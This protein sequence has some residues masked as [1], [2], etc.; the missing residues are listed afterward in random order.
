LPPPPARRCLRGGQAPR[1][2]V[3]QAAFLLR[4]PIERQRLNAAI[5]R[6]VARHE[7]LRTVF[8]RLAGMEHPLQEVR[9]DVHLELADLGAA[10]IGI[11]GESALRE[12]FRR[13]GENEFDLAGGPLLRCGLARLDAGADLLVLTLPALAG[14]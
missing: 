3:S 14:D 12:L 13:Q 1:V 6:A 7:A 9:E 2:F 11:G 4:R 5:D 8:P 10:P